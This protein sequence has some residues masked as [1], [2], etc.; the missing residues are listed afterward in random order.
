MRDPMF[1]VL[2]D[3]KVIH[4]KN[5]M[6]IQEMR[7]LIA[8]LKVEVERLKK[9]TLDGHGLCIEQLTLERKITAMLREALEDIAC[10]RA[11]LGY[12]KHARKALAR[13]KEM[14]EKTTQEDQ[15]LMPCPR[16][17]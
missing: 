15:T 5:A 6:E 14:R 1:A 8:A 3:K 2:K 11:S 17:E 12:A 13:E 9:Y 4:V 10:N 7:N 16:N